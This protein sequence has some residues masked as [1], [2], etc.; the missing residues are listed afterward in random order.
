MVFIRKR[1]NEFLIQRFCDGFTGISRKFNNWVNFSYVM[2]KRSG[3]VRHWQR[4]LEA[5]TLANH[6]FHIDGGFME[7]ND[8][9]HNG[10]TQPGRATPVILFEIVFE[11]VGY[12][13]L[14]V[15]AVLIDDPQVFFLL[16]LFN[17]I[18][19]KD[20][21]LCI[22]YRCPDRNSSLWT[23]TAHRFQWEVYLKKQTRIVEKLHQ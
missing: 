9:F 2:Q 6:T 8:S 5:G 18:L 14:K 7:I 20:Q 21:C 15:I 19:F 16:M 23:V 1:F 3:N 11:E 13:F 10:Q 17:V 4:K 22:M 12:K